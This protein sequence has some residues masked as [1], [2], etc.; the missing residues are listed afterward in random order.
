MKRASSRSA[1]VQG[2]RQLARVQ[3]LFERLRPVGTE[4]D[5][6]GNR[7][8]FCDQYVGLLLLYFFNTTLT[9]LRALQRATDPDTVQRWLGL[10]RR[11][12]LGSL[13]EAA[14]VF[15]PD[16]LRGVLADLAAR[17]GPA[18]LPSDREAL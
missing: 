2:A 4:R 5:K 10:N 18:A 7:Q 14:G 13:S 6:A 12:S 17:I 16:L 15:D 8:F 1:E 3:A 11:V 9:S